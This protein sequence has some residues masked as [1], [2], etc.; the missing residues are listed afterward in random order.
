MPDE[1]MLFPNICGLACTSGT[2]ASTPF[3]A[4]LPLDCG[5]SV[6][7][8]WGQRAAACRS[9]GAARRGPYGGKAAAAWQ[10]H[11]GPMLSSCL[12]THACSAPHCAPWQPDGAARRAVQGSVGAGWPLRL[13]QLR[14]PPQVQRRLQLWPDPRE[15]GR[16]VNWQRGAWAGGLREG[17]RGRGRARE[18]KHSPGMSARPALYFAGQRHLQ[19]NRPALVPPNIFRTRTPGDPRHACAGGAEAPSPAPAVQEEE[20]PAPSPEGDLIFRRL[21]RA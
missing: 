18:M 1:G 15:A 3:Y 14:D 7:C 10:T 13:A 11:G 8:R 12:P 20:A 6:A 2:D 19:L 4:Y 5:S 16:W 21:L 17:A 9:G